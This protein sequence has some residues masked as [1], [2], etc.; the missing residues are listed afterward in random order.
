LLSDKLA[1]IASLEK[2]MS[3]FSLHHKAS[4]TAPPGFTPRGG[5]LVS[6]KF[7][8]GQWYRAKVRRASPI[9]KE[10]ELTF[11]D[12][13][14]QDTVAFSNIRP[15]DPKFR[16]LPGQAH[17]ARLSFVQLLSPDSEYH[18]EALDRF[19]AL[20]EG[21]KLIANVDHKEGNLMHLRLIDPSEL[22]AKDDPFAC[23]NV[24]LVREG[25]AIIDKKGCRY[26]AS[27]P[28]AQKK[29]NEANNE[30]KKYRAGRFELGDVDE[31]D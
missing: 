20:A 21:R 9:K 26:L 25:Y 18:P 1:G 4:G 10:A 6:A 30:A 14:N 28:A 24:D 15:L 5:D 16:G 13:G 29:L 2:L 27:Y 19:R 8:D 12:Y 31:D 7:S 3:D 23:I 17:D 22:A 11:I